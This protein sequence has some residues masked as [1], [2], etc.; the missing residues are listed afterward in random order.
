MSTQTECYTRS[1][2]EA[3]EHGLDDGYYGFSYL[4]PCY[5]QGELNAWVEGYKKGKTMLAAWRSEQEASNN[6]TYS[7]TAASG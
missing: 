5:T 2:R 1:E 7:A 4:N 3:Y 6:A